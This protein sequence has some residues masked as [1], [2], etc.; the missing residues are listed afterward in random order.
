MSYSTNLKA[1]VFGASGLTGSFVTNILA[2]DHRYEKVVLFVR[3]LLPLQNPKISQIPY[4]PENPEGVADI[5]R[6]NHLFCCIGTTIKKAGSKASFYRT[7]HDLVL[8]IGRIAAANGV[9]S[10]VLI[11]SIGANPNSSNNYLRTKGAVENSLRRLNFNNLSI[12]RPSMLLGIRS[13]YRFGE[14]AG[15]FIMKIVQP[16]LIGKLKKYRGIHAATVAKAM[17][18]AAFRENGI[19]VYESDRLEALANATDNPKRL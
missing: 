12:V 3:N 13:E 17:I 18:V 8:N 15:K 7:D 4:D 9:S 10:F 1:I 11:S 14:E 16:L 19:F 6:G 5:I 2:E